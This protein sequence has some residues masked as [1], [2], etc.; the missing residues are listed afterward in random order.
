MNVYLEQYQRYLC[1]KLPNNINYIKQENV[2]TCR[3]LKNGLWSWTPNKDY[4]KSKNISYDDFDRWNKLETQKDKSAQGK[5][6]TKE[7]YFNKRTKIIL[8]IIGI[9]L[10]L[11]LVKKY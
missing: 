10:L 8:L 9:L 4:I 6:D 7:P 11:Y 2:N 3:N 1:D 5:D